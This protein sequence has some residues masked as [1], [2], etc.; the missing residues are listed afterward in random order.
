VRTDTSSSSLPHN[1]TTSAEQL[2]ES[3]ASLTNAAIEAIAAALSASSVLLSHEAGYVL[4][5][6]KNT[7]ALRR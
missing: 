4:G 2:G 6:M 1:A 5:Q 3:D 7:H